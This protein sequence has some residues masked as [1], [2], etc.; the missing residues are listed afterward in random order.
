VIL[1]RR[2]LLL[3]S[4]NHKEGKKRNLL[5]YEV[6]GDDFE[7]RSPTLV[8]D[9]CPCIS[10][11]FFL[12]F[13]I[14]K[15]SKMT[16]NQGKTAD[17]EVEVIKRPNYKLTGRGKTHAATGS[18]FDRTKFVPTRIGDGDDE[19]KTEIDVRAFSHCKKVTKPQP[20]SFLRKQNGVG[21]HSP[22]YAKKTVNER[23]E[24]RHDVTHVLFQ[25]KPVKKAYKKRHN[26]PNTE[27]R[28]FYERGDLPVHVD[29]NGSIPK[30]AWKVAIDRLDFHHYLPL[31][32]DG[33][34]ETELPFNFLAEEGVKDMVG[35]GGKKI[36]PVIPQLIIPIKTALD[37][38]DP[39]VIVRVI[40]VL[41]ALVVAD[42]SLENGGMI[43]QALVPYYR[44]I[45]PV[46]NLYKGKNVN[47]GDGIDYSQRKNENLG[48]LINHTLELFETYGGPDAYINIKYLIPTYQSVNQ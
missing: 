19:E 41:Q 21:G 43:G 7:V 39:E 15:E 12:H 40:R 5:Q 16:R 37:T 35:V 11:C 14:C 23:L 10:N 1:S 38:R 22:F 28:R 25:K 27:F 34:R 26:P 3:N 44:Q 8:K 4:F 29:Q 33:L 18:P 24:E 45:L 9:C 48:E 6:W 47:I 17:E 30:M 13:C 36:L 42:L 32:F 20:G 2:I 31:F 46:F